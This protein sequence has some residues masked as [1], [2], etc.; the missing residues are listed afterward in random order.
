MLMSRRTCWLSIS[1]IALALTQGL[2]VSQ[3]I[4]GS[5]NGVIRDNTGAV[6]AGTAL[7]AANIDTGQ[8]VRTTTDE[9]GA[10]TFPLLR[11]GR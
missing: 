9:I 1:V 10:Y 7:T 8:E 4:T 11:P 3:E 5:I 6:L 2:A